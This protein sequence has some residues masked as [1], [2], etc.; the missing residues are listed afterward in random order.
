[1][2]HG[3]IT[4]AEA[5]ALGRLRQWSNDRAALRAARTCDYRRTGWQTRQDRQFDARLVRVID[6]DRAM[7]KLSPQEQLALILTHRDREQI[8]R[9]AVAIG[10]CTRTVYTLLVEARRKLAAEL[11]KLDLL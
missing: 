3:R 5:L 1:M 8:P 11:E 2:A 7:A 4:T 9:V 10:C 6:F